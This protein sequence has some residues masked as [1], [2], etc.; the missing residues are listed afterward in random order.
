[1]LVRTKGPFFET[2]IERQV[3]IVMCNT[4]T[5]EM[6]ADNHK[7]LLI[8]MWSLFTVSVEIVALKDV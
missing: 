5:C 1:M 7:F 3:F 4:N 2:I 6:C 8:P